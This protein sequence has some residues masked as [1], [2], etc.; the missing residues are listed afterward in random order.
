M[1]IKMQL[2]NL[3]YLFYICITFMYICFIYMQYIVLSYISSKFYSYFILWLENCKGNVSL[4]IMFM[5]YFQQ[6]IDIWIYKYI[7]YIYCVCV[8]CVLV[9]CVCKLGFILPYHATSSEIFLFLFKEL[10]I[11]LSIFKIF[12]ILV[13]GMPADV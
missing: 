7:I 2:K 10:P 5:S 6:S 3:Y 4:W 1:Q 9:F 11:I 12:D 8:N 13:W